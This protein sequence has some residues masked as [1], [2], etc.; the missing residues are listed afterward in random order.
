MLVGRLAAIALTDAGVWRRLRGRT[1]WCLAQQR[2]LRRPGSPC[3]GWSLL[4]AG[5][6]ASVAADVT[7]AAVQ[8]ERLEDGWKTGISHLTNYLSPMWWLPLNS[9]ILFLVFSNFAAW[10]LLSR[11]W[12]FVD[13]FATQNKKGKKY[14]RE[15]Q[16][17]PIR[18]CNAPRKAICCHTF[19][20][21]HCS[22][23]IRIRIRIHS[24]R[25]LSLL[26]KFPR[27]PSIFVV[28]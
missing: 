23:C 2:C 24:P 3:C 7:A 26:S 4:A 8:L 19:L 16:G 27:I 18:I 10:P 21:K 9:L 20:A 14:R 5:A 6:T 25:L 1:R 11:A 28:N 12:I 17:K 15:M 22:A 13:F